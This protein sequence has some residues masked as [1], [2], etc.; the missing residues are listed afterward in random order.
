MLT[1]NILAFEEKFNLP[2]GFFDSL[3]EEDDWSFIIK[4]HSVVEAICTDALAYHFGE[5]DLRE[6]LSQLELSN[7]K[8]GKI[9]FLSKV[10]LITSDHKRIIVELSK[11]RNNYV[12]RISDITVSLSDKY[13]EL[14]KN[15]KSNFLAAFPNFGAEFFLMAKEHLGFEKLEKYEVTNKQI[16]SGSPIDIKLQIWS[17]V[18]G[19]INHFSE[20]KGFS[21]FKRWE[22]AKF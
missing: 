14:D 15:Q 21:D 20:I 16:N 2:V 3:L 9:V 19:L 11:L 8:V 7:Q 6:T 12:H 22:K 5:S 4:L 1:S 10:G 13:A 17:S 18:W